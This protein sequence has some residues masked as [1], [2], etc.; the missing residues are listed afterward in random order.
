MFNDYILQFD[1]IS[2]GSLRKKNIPGNKFFVQN[3]DQNMLAHT[4]MDLLVALAEVFYNVN[5]VNV[6]YTGQKFNC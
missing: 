3:L 6:N 1:I 4:V 5:Y 2:L